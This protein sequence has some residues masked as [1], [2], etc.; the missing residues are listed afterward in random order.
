MLLK[1]SALITSRLAGSAHPVI[2]GSCLAGSPYPAI[3]GSCVAGSPYFC[4]YKLDF[5]IFPCGF[6]EPRATNLNLLAWIY[7]VVVASRRFFLVQ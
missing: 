5:A 1:I 6:P 4:D 3:S 7:I 2:P